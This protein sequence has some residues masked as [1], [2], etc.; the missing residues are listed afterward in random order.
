MISK[1]QL[2]DIYNTELKPQLASF[3]KQR[4][5]VIALYIVAIIPLIISFGMAFTSA[6]RYDYTE[7]SRTILMYTFLAA[8]IVFALFFV[9]I[10]IAEHKRSAYILRFKRDIVSMI[11]PLFEPK[12]TYKKDAQ[13]GSI[14]YNASKLF[15]RPY[16]DYKGEDLVHGIM[17]KTEFKSSELRTS[18]D[19]RS[20]GGTEQQTIFSGLFFHSDF[21]KQFIGETFLVHGELQDQAMTFSNTSS[22]TKIVKLEN[23]QF[24][25]IFATRSTNQIEARYILTPN[26]MEALLSVQKLVKRAMFISFVN[27][28]MYCAISLPNGLFETSVTSRINFKK[29]E[30]MYDLYN[31]NAI[32][33]EELNL[34]TRIW[35]KK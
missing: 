28:H 17:G 7:E 19:V 27:K 4:K 18:Y 32:L 5:N 21:N 10:G 20:N 30:K 34:N 23:T 13:I 35:T 16:D 3:E 12:W 1:K 31:L 9:F 26:I 15:N 14:A 29:I 8:F 6:I 25:K 11:V 22:K 2:L 33:I 24:A